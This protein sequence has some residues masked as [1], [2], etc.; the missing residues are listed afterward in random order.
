MS[1]HG[2]PPA[3]PGLGGRRDRPASAQPLVVQGPDNPVGPGA[4]GPVAA[5]STGAVGP[6]V[7]IGAV[8]PVG[9]VGAVGSDPSIDPNT[10][11]HMSRIARL[12]YGSGNNTQTTY[13]AIKANQDID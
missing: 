5:G 13:P 11:A 7:S 3:D 6:V 9:P 1:N 12:T 4:V 10:R 2:Y 8:G